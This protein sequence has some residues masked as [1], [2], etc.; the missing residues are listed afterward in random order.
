M[1]L[2]LILL[3][4]CWNVFATEP[5]FDLP[6]NDAKAQCAEVERVIRECGENTITDGKIHKCGNVFFKH[7]HF[8][9]SD[10]D[11]GQIEG[12]GLIITNHNGQY[13][14][15]SWFGDDG[16]YASLNNE[17]YFKVSTG[18]KILDK[19]KTLLLKINNC[20]IVTN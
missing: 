19:Q 11:D 9:G 6:K 18:D 20:L 1:K 8:F 10:A 2:I 14:G 3:L 17:E 7:V 13:I 12:P 5:H 16:L 4:F 15:T